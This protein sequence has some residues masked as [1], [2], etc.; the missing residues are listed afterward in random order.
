MATKKKQ[1]KTSKVKTVFISILALIIGVLIGFVLASFFQ[2]TRLEFEVVGE[3][4]TS[5]SLDEEYTETG[6]TCTF[7][8]V[9]KSSNVSVSY[10]DSL[11]NKVNNIDTSA[12]GSYLVKYTYEE[13]GI[14]VSITK[15]VKIVSMKS[16]G[17]SPMEKLLTRPC[18]RKFWRSLTLRILQVCLCWAASLL[19][20]KT[21]RRFCLLLER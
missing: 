19:N 17:T 10:Y 1:K 9:D 8:G 6:V 14:K 21:K 20:R 12:V 4:V 7:D 3:N 13:N 5:I 15:V 11:G 2:T 16:L 18:R